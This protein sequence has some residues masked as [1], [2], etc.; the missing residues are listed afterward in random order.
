MGMQ[1]TETRKC[2]CDGCKISSFETACAEDRPRMYANLFVR[3][4]VCIP[5]P[6]LT[7]GFDR[8]FCPECVRKRIGH[9]SNL[10]I[11]GEER[12]EAVR[13]ALL[14]LWDALGLSS[15][16]N[17]KMPGKCTE[18]HYRLYEFVGEALLGADCPARERKC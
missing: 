18:E 5:N 16:N 8:Y 13:K 9:T 3:G 15:T 17:F 4:W 12:R 1:G 7:K 14:G 6:L 10:E 11:D 2:V